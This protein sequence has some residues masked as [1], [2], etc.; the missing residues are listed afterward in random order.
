MNAASVAAGAACAAVLVSLLGGM[1]LL[2]YNAGRHSQRLTAAETA[3]TDLQRGQAE[4]D[5]AISAWDQ[6][7]QLVEEV[8]GDVKSLIT[9]R[10]KPGRY[11][12]SRQD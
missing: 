8:R 7:R 10:I 5:K 11:G 9:G 4:H 1:F 2:I 12:E 3:I 6:V